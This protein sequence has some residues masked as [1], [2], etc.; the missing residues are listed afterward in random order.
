MSNT[1]AIPQI[2]SIELSKMLIC[3]HVYLQHGVFLIQLTI[4]KADEVSVDQRIELLTGAV[5]CLKH[6]AHSFTLH[7]S[8]FHWKSF[9]F[10]HS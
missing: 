5:T 9:P 7:C 1:A 4:E 2:L 3:F 8:L 6:L 10:T